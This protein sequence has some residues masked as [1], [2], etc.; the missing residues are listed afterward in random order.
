MDIRSSY[1][2][3]LGSTL[4]PVEQV[5][6]MPAGQVIAPMPAVPEE[7]G[8]DRSRWATFSPALRTALLKA[9]LPD[10]GESGIKAVLLKFDTCAPDRGF[11]PPTVIEVPVQSPPPPQA[12]EVPAQ[13]PTPQPPLA[14]SPVAAPAGFAPGQVFYPAP[15]FMQAPA[16]Q[17]IQPTGGPQYP[18]MLG[19]FV[20]G[21]ALII[22]AW[23]LYEVTRMKNELEH[24]RGR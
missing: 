20:L 17:A 9:K 7:I 8:I 11:V 14:Q 24:K 10:L 3:R 22:T 12:Q 6:P 19:W 1:T 4:A 15:V 21:G 18:P 23:M 16:G 2:Q 5:A 13:Q